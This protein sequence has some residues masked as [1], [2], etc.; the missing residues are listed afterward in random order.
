MTHHLNKGILF[1]G[2]LLMNKKYTFDDV[3][4]EASFS[5]VQSRKSC[6]TDSYLFGTNVEV[7]I[8]N[9]N[10]D[11]VVNTS[12]ANGIHSAG[13]L[14]ALHR[15]MPVGD[16]ITAFQ[17][18][19]NAWASVGLKENDIERIDALLNAGARKFIIDTA[20]GANQY[21]IDTLDYIKQKSF[22]AKVM[23][24]N[25]GSPNSLAMFLDNCNYY[26]PDAV[27]LGVGSGSNCAT[28]VV[29]GVGYPQLS[30][31]MDSVKIAKQNNVIIVSDGGAKT[32]GDVCKALAA[33][34]DFVMTGSFFAGAKD[35]PG[36]T[37]NGYKVYRGSASKESYETQGKTAEHRT[38][39]GIARKVKEKDETAFDIVKH[40]QAGIKSSMSYL[41]ATT[42][43]E[44]RIRA[45]FV[46][47]THHG[48]IQGTPHGLRENQ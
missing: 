46:E 41:N 23:V 17:Q 6:S 26:T 32:F 43:D 47:V 38:P 3:M 18:S 45:S 34:A 1:I 35:A 5:K 8:M 31:I 13:G 21:V 44:Y 15:F 10:M 2:E 27:K 33:G 12:V 37:E 24:G 29:T 20:H 48:Y 30:L 11:T 4:L 36:T 22:N 7:P 16:N 9:A 14:A 42:L 28:S 40:I 25:F 19:P 39:E